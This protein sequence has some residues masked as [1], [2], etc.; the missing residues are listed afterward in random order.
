MR[1][2]K[3]TFADGYTLTTSINGTD[4][5]IRA[6]YLGNAFQFGDTDECPR[7]NLQR[8]VSVAIEPCDMCAPYGTPGFVVNA[9]QVVPCWQCNPT[10]A[11]T[12]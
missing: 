11:R 8:A 4:E 9:W 12:R 1:T 3:V 6:Y 10:P 5:E 7:D 2:V